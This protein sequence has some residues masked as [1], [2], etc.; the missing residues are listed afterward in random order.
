MCGLNILNNDLKAFGAEKISKLNIL[1]IWVKNIM[2]NH[3]F[4]NSKRYFV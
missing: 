1:F 2:I 3:I 4:V